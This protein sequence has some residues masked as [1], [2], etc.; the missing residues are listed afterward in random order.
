MFA[1]FAVMRPLHELLWYLTEAQALAAAAPVHDALAAAAAEMTRRTHGR[2]GELAGLDW[3]RS[4][5][6]PPRCFAAPANWPAV[7][8]QRN[9]T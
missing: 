8:F 4:A 5:P 3:M 9:G 7:R 6:M 1:A 2:P